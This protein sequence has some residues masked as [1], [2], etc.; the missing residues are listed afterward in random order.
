MIYFAVAAYMDVIVVFGQAES[1]NVTVPA[2]VTGNEAAMRKDV[3]EKP[4]H[5]MG[6]TLSRSSTFSCVD[7]GSQSQH[8]KAEYGKKVA[9]TME[10]LAMQAAAYSPCKHFVF[11]Y[12]L[13]RCHCLRAH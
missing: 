13:F 5:F 11:Q 4:P 6:R 2:V 12:T 9:K 3:P 7:A 8:A 10:F 1:K